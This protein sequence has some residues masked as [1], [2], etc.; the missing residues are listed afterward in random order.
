MRNFVLILALVVIAGFIF[1]LEKKHGGPTGAP[2]TV[3]ADITIATS[4]APTG[5]QAVSQGNVKTAVPATLMSRA[6]KAKKYEVAKEIVNPSGFVNTDP[7]TIQSLIGKKVILVDFWTYSCINC[8]R[9]LPYLNSWYAK[10]KNDGLVVVGVHTPEF[11]F[12]HDITNVQS[13]VKKYGVEYPVVLDNNFAT[14]S[15]YKNQYWPHEYLI[16]IDGFIVHDHIGEGSYD[17]TEAA[18][19]A[20]LNERKQV[21]GE[22]GALTVKAGGPGNADAPQGPI[23]SPETYFG[24][25]REQ[26]LANMPTSSCKGS[27]CSYAFSATS[28]FSGYEL[29]GSWMMS[30]EY[31]ELKTLPGGV[32]LHFYA[33]K[34]HFVAGANTPVRAKI[35]LDGKLVTSANEG[36]DVKN[37]IVTVGAHD[38]YN[39]V[40]LHGNSGDHILEIQFLDAGV[41][42]FTFTFG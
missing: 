13:A 3:N 8:E 33:N 40:D 35:L 11:D 31:A 4:S 15:A 1:I 10:Y 34:V 38:L 37:G 21:L 9:T 2:G 42:A 27:T 14:W 7:I 39:L 26:Y 17:E 36:K 25:N 5:E 23:L 12:E 29:S 28:T 41:D 6:E 16:D 20:A 18:I 24:S 22:K 30:P 19:V 32:R